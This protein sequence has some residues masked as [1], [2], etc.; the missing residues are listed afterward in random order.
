MP[1][2]YA[3]MTKI[4]V[5]ARRARA[6]LPNISC[7]LDEPVAT[8]SNG[9]PPPENALDNC[10]PGASVGSGLDVSSGGTATVM[11]GVDPVAFGSMTKP[12]VD[13]LE[14]LEL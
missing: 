3:H 10:V 11:V 13:E 2:D 9:D 5:V 1:C 7:W 8:M 12:L 6:A 4:N 14:L